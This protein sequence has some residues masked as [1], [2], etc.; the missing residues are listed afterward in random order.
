MT[1][2]LTAVPAPD[3][4]PG[5]RVITID[6]RHGTTTLTVVPPRDPD[7]YKPHEAASVRLALL[8]HYTEEGCNCTRRLAR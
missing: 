3:L 5:A 2:T 4:A 6:C 1:A 7:A 8:K